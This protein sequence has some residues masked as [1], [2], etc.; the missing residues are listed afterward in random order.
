MSLG[1][2][3][4]ILMFLPMHHHKRSGKLLPIVT[5]ILLPFICIVSDS[6][7]SAELSFCNK[8]YVACQVYSTS[9]P[10]LK[11]ACQAVQLKCYY[12]T[13]RKAS[14]EAKEMKQIK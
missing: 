1:G 5:N 12:A 3:Y 7:H 13:L 14:L 4:V 6:F 9:Y 8:Q 11:T 2:K 10:A